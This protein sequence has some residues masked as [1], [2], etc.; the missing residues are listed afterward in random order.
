[1]HI[2]PAGRQARTLQ[3][4]PISRDLFR[5]V[6]RRDC[7]ETI[8]TRQMAR[9]GIVAAL[10]SLTLGASAQDGGKDLQKQ[11]DDVRGA[12]PKFAIPMREVGDR[13]QNMYFAAEHGNWALA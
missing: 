8:M 9:A 13:F 1:M 12:L 3:L 4:S 7:R 10:L 6:R 5:E 11:I 2:K